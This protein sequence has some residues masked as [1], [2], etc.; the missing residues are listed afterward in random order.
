EAHRDRPDRLDVAVPVLPAEPPDLFDHTGRVGHRVGVGHRV[1]AREAARGS[2][3]RAGLDGLGVLAAGLAQVGVQVHQTRQHD[4]AGRLEHV[5][6]TGVE[7]HA[8]LGDDR[9][10]DPHI[11]DSGAGDVPTTDHVAAHVPAS[12]LAATSD[13]AGG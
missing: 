1:Y 12:A 13:C 3:Q 4:Q 11:G 6:I 2:C 7:T 9:P 5:R 10:L 8:D